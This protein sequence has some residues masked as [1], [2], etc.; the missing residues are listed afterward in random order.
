MSDSDEEVSPKKSPRKRAGK[1]GVEVD[2]HEDDMPPMPEKDYLCE[3]MEEPERNAA[4]DLVLTTDE[5]RIKYGYSWDYCVVLKRVPL[6]TASSLW[7]A[8]KLG[9]AARLQYYE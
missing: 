5:F 3:L 4:G 6:R 8:P 2:W 1:D 9:T 7:A